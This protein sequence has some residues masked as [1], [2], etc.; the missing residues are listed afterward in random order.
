IVGTAVSWVEGSRP[1]RNRARRSRVVRAVNQKTGLGLDTPGTVLFGI[2]PR[3]P[4]TIGIR[5]TFANHDCIGGAIGDTRNARLGRQVAG[6][7]MA[8]VFV[9]IGGLGTIVVVG[10]DEHALGVDVVEI[11]VIT[12]GGRDGQV[13]R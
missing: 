4:A 3:A 2:R 12:E 13:T 10:V 11:A 9:V 1:S 8:A 5:R 6:P 7:G